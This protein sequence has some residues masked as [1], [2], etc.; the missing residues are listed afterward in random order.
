MNQQERPTNNNQP[1]LVT[2]ESNGNKSIETSSD[3]Q[4]T[5]EF[6]SATSNNEIDLDNLAGFNPN[7]PLT[8]ESQ[9]QLAQDA[10]TTQP[11]PIAQRGVPRAV[12]MLILTGVT[13]SMFLLVWQFI[14]PKSATKPLAQKTAIPTK[15][16]AIKDEKPELLARLA[17]QDQQKLVAQPPQTQKPP[18]PQPDVK[19]TPKASTKPTPRPVIQR[20]TPRPVTTR[21]ATPPPPPRTIVRTVTVPAAAPPPKTIVRTV[22][23]PAAAPPPK[24][25]VR[26]V[27]VPAPIPKPTP[28]AKPA[29][30]VPTFNPKPTAA[31]VPEKIDPFERWNQLAQ[32]GQTRGNIEISQSPPLQSASLPTSDRV[33]STSS[34]ETANI[35]EIQV[36]SNPTT[37]AEEFD[38][39][40]LP[41][42][43]ETPINASN[44]LPQDVTNGD[45]ELVTIQIP[46]RTARALPENAIALKGHLVEAPPNSESLPVRSDSLSEVAKENSE[47]LAVTTSSEKPSASSNL[48]PGAYGILNR[49]PVSAINT[50]ITQMVLGTTASGAVSVPLLWD[51]DS[52]SQIFDRFAIT[53]TEDMKAADGKVALKAGTVVIAKALRVNKRN[54]MVQASGSA[55]VYTD[56]SGQVK[57]QQIPSDAILITGENGKPLIASGYLDPGDD[58]AKQDILVGLLSGAGRVG[59]VLIEP[60]V[61]SRSTISSGGFSRDTITVESQNPQI[62]SAV[63]DGFFTPLA[64]RIEKRSD[65]AIEESLNRPNIAMVPKGTKVSITINRFFEVNR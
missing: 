14:K 26:T 9:Y 1:N 63:L 27:T 23:V 44:S 35:P 21:P 24:T 28:S 7:L 20:A 50:P 49:R 64:R 48:S 53:L 29:P 42:G 55:I 59:Q 37:D 33:E 62:W 45:R 54:R 8:L 40:S 52:D 38:D 47:F 3:S 34:I 5:Q 41:R 61:R 46:E 19:S 58:I 16:S 25:I 43:E 65:R 57:Q 31:P 15:E 60:R 39:S 22:T 56:E 11:P 30:S 12:T 17:Y 10:E 36:S 6:E 18:Q 51:E 32:L 4:L 2:T 13:I